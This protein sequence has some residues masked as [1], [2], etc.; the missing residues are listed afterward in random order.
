MENISCLSL[1]AAHETSLLCTDSTKDTR[2]QCNLCIKSHPVCVYFLHV[3]VLFFSHRK[4]WVF[5]EEGMCKCFQFI[6]GIFLCLCLFPKHPFI[7]LKPARPGALCRLSALLC[8][9]AACH[10]VMHPLNPL[11]RVLPRV[12]T[13]QTGFTYSQTDGAKTGCQN[14]ES[15]KIDTVFFIFIHSFFIKKIN[16]FFFKY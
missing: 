6:Y 8:M 1:Q 14:K 4:N 13:A 10:T 15:A 3:F 5:R 16:L 7:L 11:L 2:Y 12:V 9:P